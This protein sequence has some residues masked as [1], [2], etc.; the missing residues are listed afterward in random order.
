MTRI[1]GNVVANSDA[2]WRK[3]ALAI[4]SAVVIATPVDTGR[5]RSN[6]VVRV[7]QPYGG[8]LDPYVPGEK[9]STASQ[10]A[11]R[12]LEQ[13]RQAI[14][15]ATAQQRVIY[16]TNNLDYID[17]LNKGHSAQAPAG[18]VELAIQ[19]GVSAIAG[20]RLLP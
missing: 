2:A 4:H 10:N 16:I 20:T 3:V 9:G 15:S 8:R 1:A 19:A 7:G 14:A 18:F 13:G 6:W 17:A 12:A 5:A 11:D